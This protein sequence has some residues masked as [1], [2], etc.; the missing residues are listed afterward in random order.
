[1]CTDTDAEFAKCFESFIEREIPCNIEWIPHG[2]ILTE[3]NKYLL[4]VE[5]KSRIPEDSQL[6]LSNF[7]TNGMIHFN[8]NSYWYGMKYIYFYQNCEIK[9][10][11]GDLL[12][13]VKIYERTLNHWSPSS[14]NVPI[15]LIYSLWINMF[16]EAVV[17]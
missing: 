14:R 3:E 12:Y 17:R 6:V 4:L 5:V 7:Q 15:L 9:V 11:A 16:Q 10:R 2:T 13:K 1:M 8:L